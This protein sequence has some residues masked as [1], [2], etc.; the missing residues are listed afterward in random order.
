MSATTRLVIRCHADQMPTLVTTNTTW[1][2][3]PHS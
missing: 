3:D 1:I 2:L